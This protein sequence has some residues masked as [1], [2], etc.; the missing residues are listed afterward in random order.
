MVRGAAVYRGAP[1]PGPTIN[2]FE[3]RIMS[4]NG[5][6]GILLELF[7]RLGEGGKFFVEFGVEDGMEC[8]AAYLAKHCEWSGVMLDGDPSREQ[9]LRR[10]QG[11]DRVTTGREFIT[12]EN[13]LE[14]FEKYRVPHEF[15]LLSIDIDGND[16]W[17]WKEVGAA[18][19]PRVVV[20]EYNA[21]YPPPARWVMAYDAEHLWDGTNY[22]GASL[23]SYVALG[24]ELGYAFLG[25]ESNG[26]NAFFV[27]AD[28]V[29]EL[30]DLR[31][32][33]AEESYHWPRRPLLRRSAFPYRYG[34][35]ETI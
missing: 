11:S 18:Y 22:F 2:D 31:P 21:T 24:Q 13:I 25:T 26:L 27:R 15:D 16:Y 8:N 17:V 3:D 10:N 7:R 35:Y 34:P 30:G 33:A 1:A 14:L 28:L 19:R 5:E 6:D 32:R 9:T 29:D 20:M 23:A 12:R 4:Q